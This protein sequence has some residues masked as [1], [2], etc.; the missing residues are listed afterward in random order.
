MSD[1]PSSSLYRAL[2]PV[3][4]E[5]RLLT[6]IAVDAEDRVTCRL[7]TVPI[8]ECPPYAALSYVWGQAT[9][10]EEI[11]VD[12]RAFQATPS[13]ARALRYVPRHW[14]T[15]YPGRAL[16]ELRLWADAV[17]IN[18]RDLEERSRQVRLMG[19]IFSGAE[20]V[21]CW[22]P[23]GISHSLDPQTFSENMQDDVLSTAFQTL[24]LI[25]REL[26]LVEQEAGV[27]LKRL[28]KTLHWHGIGFDDERLVQWLAKYPELIKTAPGNTWT[29]W[30]KNWEAV[31]H[32]ADLQYWKRVWIFQEIVLSREALLMCKSSCTSLT[33]TVDRVY[34]WFDWLQMCSL[35]TPSFVF[36]DFWESL[37][38]GYAVSAAVVRLTLDPWRRRGI[39]APIQSWDM[40]RMTSLSLAATN[41]KDKVYGMLGVT[42]I[43]LRPDYSDQ[44][45]VAKV[46]RDMTA[47]WLQDYASTK[48]D[49][50]SKVV[51]S[52]SREL[53]FLRYGGLRHYCEHADCQHWSSWTPNFLH[54]DHEMDDYLYFHTG[55]ADYSVFSDEQNQ[56]LSYIQDSSL[57]VTGLHVDCVHETYPQIVKVSDFSDLI[58]GLFRNN[59]SKY[60]GVRPK[61]R[62]LRDLFELLFWENLRGSIL[63]ARLHVSD[64]ISFNYLEFAFLFVWAMISTKSKWNHDR[65]ATA[66]SCTPTFNGGSQYRTAI[67]T[68]GLESDTNAGFVFSLRETF[69]DLE[70]V[71]EEELGV[72]SGSD[73]DEV[74][75]SWLQALVDS[76]ATG[77]MPKDSDGT[78][79]VHLRRITDQLEGFAMR[80]ACLFLTSRGNFGLG[81]RR[82]ITRGDALCV[83]K[84]WESV[85]A[86]RET[87]DHF[88]YVGGTKVQGMMEG[89][90]AQLLE[91]GLA[92]VRQFELK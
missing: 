10:P 66:L 86:L 73:Y 58:S 39:G 83:L 53:W 36:S 60:S 31:K 11:Q 42:G 82:T 48:E 44:T 79:A 5:I 18:Q 77:G 61:R 1:R 88:I 65:D 62:L 37:V 29:A 63:D 24:E 26:R 59:A 6:A 71:A 52:G 20:L 30:N 32:L 13:L 87:G 12:G 16:A 46:F 3:I 80:R 50:A 47:A 54:Y 8:H 45:S 25:N 17:C 76:E 15:K 67:E 43:D 2:D 72:R 7:V 14:Q 35:P 70:E 33:E 34:R 41:P 78:L 40:F 22:M 75:S 90:A 21:V 19:D 74:P 49:T 89:Q 55:N 56:E 23:D 27:N 4:N 68:L 81:P 9:D 85:A 92:E 91:D 69:L 57:F 38:S 28:H 64:P 84:G 51:G